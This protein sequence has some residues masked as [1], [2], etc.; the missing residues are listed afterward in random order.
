MKILFVSDNLIHGFGGG[1]IECKK[2]YHAL[3]QY[4]AQKGHELKVISMDNDVPEK[5]EVKLEKNRKIDVLCRILGHSSYMYISLLKNKKILEEY[6]PD[7]VYFVRSRLGFMARFFKKHNK[8]CIVISFHQQEHPLKYA[9][10]ADSHGL[11]GTILK[12]LER[13]AVLNDEKTTIKYTD[14]LIY[15]TKRN[16]R[17]YEELYN[18][19]ND[20]ADV[21]PIC[22][23]NTV[24]L[25][26]N[27]GKKNIVFIGSLDYAGNVAAVKSLLNDIWS[28][29]YSDN[30]ELN[31][32][33][34]GR[35]PGKELVEQIKRIPNAQ[36]ISNF[37]A[38]EDIIPKYSVMLAPI[39]KGAGMKVK[40]AEALSMGLM[41]IGSEEALVGYEDAL[42]ESGVKLFQCDEINGYKEKIDE[43]LKMTDDELA[44]S[45]KK[46]KDIFN[47]YYSYTY[48]V[49]ALSNILDRVLK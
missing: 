4:C 16:V 32:I 24:D 44:E 36:L 13:R 31:L 28:K 9:Y 6:N 46:H 2:H 7:A 38:V 8:N 5:S 41:V 49:N 14:K 39:E 33:I 17:R 20:S 19:K 11:K 48:S 10:F 12:L 26:I 21:I 23:E 35:N 34:A 18:V 47:K 3:K 45:E 42:N 30:N 27:N 25:T 15:L 37:K 40:V 1:C 29:Y 43:Y 22:M